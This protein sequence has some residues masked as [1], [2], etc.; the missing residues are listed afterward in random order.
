MKMLV[1]TFAF[2]VIIAFTV[3]AVLHLND[4]DVL[5]F[6][7]DER[8]SID[9]DCHDDD[10]FDESEAIDADIQKFIDRVIDF[11][12]EIEFDRHDV[13]RLSIMFSILLVFR[14]EIE[15]KV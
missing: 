12:C 5:S 3:N 15:M 8:R 10:C 2:H 6:E 13:V 11:H 7:N 14:V 4:D 9:D 1:S